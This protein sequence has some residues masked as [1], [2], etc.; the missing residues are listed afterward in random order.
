VTFTIYLGILTAI[1]LTAI[2]LALDSGHE[3]RTNI[4]SVKSKA[5]FHSHFRQ[6][7]LKIVI[8]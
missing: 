3:Y 4:I 1:L 5:L 7:M 8:K 2:L 6:G